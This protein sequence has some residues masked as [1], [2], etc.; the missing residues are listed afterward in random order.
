MFIFNDIHP[1][2]DSANFSFQCSTDGGSNYNVTTTS[3]TFRN[4]HFESDSALDLAYDSSTDQEQG[5]GFQ[6]LAE[7]F[8]SDNDQSGAG[9]LKLYTPSNTTFV[10]KY[11]A[12]CSRVSSNDNA[13]DFYVGGYFNTTSAIDAIQ[14]KMS[15]GN[16]NGY[17]QF[18]GIS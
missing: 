17:I 18:Y 13:Y 14:F 10:K 6:L 11:M 3:D 5:T 16:F 12:R 8:G 2:T 15:S 4:Y 1:E 7:N 9:V